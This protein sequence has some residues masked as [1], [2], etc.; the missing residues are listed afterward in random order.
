M[1]NMYAFFKSLGEPKIGASRV[2]AYR[3]AYACFR[4]AALWGSTMTPQDGEHV[5]ETMAEFRQLEV[6]VNASAAMPASRQW[7]MQLKKLISGAAFVAG[8][9]NSGSARDSQFECLIAAVAQS[10][11]YEI[12]FAEPDVMVHDTR[13]FHF[14]IAAKRPR[15]FGSV[16][17]NCRTGA[18][19]VAKS[20]H[21][22]IVALDLTS[23]YFGAMPRMIA[24]PDAANTLV[25]EAVGQFVVTNAADLIRWVNRRAAA[26]LL[27]L[28]IPVLVDSQERP[29][30]LT[31]TCW[32]VVGLPHIEDRSWILQ[33]A[34]R[35]ERGLF[36]TLG[37][38]EIA[39]A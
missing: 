23:C 37:D 39:T 33:F 8:H 21:P 28:Q 6:I 7:R 17:R 38:T 22:G 34:A 30:L 1:E 9:K 29:Q 3:D 35:C 24:S 16:E 31:A 5:L 32:R 10:S 11:G 27:T 4:E 12:S 2:R 36:G 15:H 14:G 18:R 20:G 19:Q 13:G 26:I 25:A